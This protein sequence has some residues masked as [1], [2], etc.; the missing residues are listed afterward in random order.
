MSEVRQEPPTMSFTAYRSIGHVASHECTHRGIL[1]YVYLCVCIIVAHHI[2]MYNISHA[3]KHIL[4]YFSLT[5][6]TE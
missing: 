4:L 3:K 5:T 2:I 6:G 1:S